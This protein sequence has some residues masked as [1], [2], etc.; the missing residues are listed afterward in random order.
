MQ[1]LDAHSPQR[2][3]AFFLASVIL[4]QRSGAGDPSDREETSYQ[5][6]ASTISRDLVDALRELHVIED[7]PLRHLIDGL[8]LHVRA[9]IWRVRN[10][11]QIHSD[12]PR[13]IMVSIPPPL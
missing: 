2:R 9:A 1:L 5:D 13:Q 8:T 3:R 10:G 12:T 7:E 4:S 6:E 11:N